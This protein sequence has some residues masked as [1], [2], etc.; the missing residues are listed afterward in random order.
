MKAIKKE[1]FNRLISSLIKRYEVIAPVKKELVSFEVIKEPKEIFLEKNSYFPVKEFFFRKNETLFEF[2]GNSVTVPVK[3]A[4]GKI[5]LGLRRCDLNSILR[6]DMAFIDEE[7]DPYYKKERENSVLIGYHCKKAEDKYCFC[8]SLKLLDFF[9][10][11]LYD[12]GKRFIVEVGSKKGNEFINKHKQYFKN[13]NT[14]LT[15]KDKIIKNSD[16]LK[17]KDISHL[18]NHPDWKKDVKLCLSCAACNVL[19][20]SCYCFD[21]NDKVNIKDLS[22][23]ERFRTWAA[24]QLRC[25]TKVAGEHVFRDKREERFK[26]RIYHQLQYFKEKHGVDLCT[27]C[28]RCIR[29]CPT[30]IDFVKTI[31][32]MK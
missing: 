28:G 20:P 22:K 21:I 1:V 17:K 18:Y 3:K 13:T 5:L 25:F 7:V 15:D 16:R 10:L 32:E 31:N 9:D 2:K 29:G 30:R 26:H 8:G 24:C 23:G 12:K 14:S 6:Q 27:G 4:K 19:C 11:M